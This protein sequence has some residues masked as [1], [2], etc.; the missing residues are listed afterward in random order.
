MWTERFEHVSAEGSVG[1]PLFREAAKLGL[2]HAK[3]I[4]SRFHLAVSRQTRDCRRTRI[5]IRDED[6]PVAVW[7]PDITLASIIRCIAA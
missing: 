2:E 1:V 4:R 3:T 6:L 5:S 7:M